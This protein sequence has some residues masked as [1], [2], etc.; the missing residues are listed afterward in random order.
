[1]I[2]AVKKFFEM[3][4]MPP[5]VNDTSIVL[6]PK[7]K[8][9][10]SLRD[11][12]PISLCNVIYKV[13]SKCLVNLLRSLLQDMISPT[14]SAFILSSMITENAIIAFECIHA[15]Q[16]GSANAGKFC[17]YK[18]DL[19][20]AYDRVDWNFLKVPLRKIGFAEKFIYWIMECVK[21]VRFSVRFNGKLLESFCPSRGLR[22]G[23]PLSPILFMFVA[24]GLTSIFH[25]QITEGNIEELKICRRGP[26]ISHL[27]FADDS[28]LF[29]KAKADQARKI[30]T[31]LRAY[32]ASTGQ[33]LSPTKCSLMLGQKVT[34]EEGAMV[35]SI[36][37]V[38]NI[39]FEEKYL[40]LPVPEGRMKDDKFQP[41]KERLM[42]KCSD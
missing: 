41:T 40:G 10:I 1:V 13:V 14:Q 11:Y 21:T 36:L 6:I 5:G 18:L 2:G 19:M 20:K 24:E 12:R 4:T 28:L 17:A 38:Q 22:Q 26:G 33:L 16:N 37:N 35:A 8:N 39:S 9:P 34:E 3:G 29:F 31:A 15:L 42:K 7:N 30:N 32:E 25:H 27:L 23:D